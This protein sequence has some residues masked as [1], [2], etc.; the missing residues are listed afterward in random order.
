MSHQAQSQLPAARKNPGKFLRRIAALAAVKTDPDD[1]V[2]E[3]QSNV[4][5]RKSVLFTEVAQKTEYQRGTQSQLFTAATDCPVQSVDYRFKGNSSG[6]MCLRIEEDFRMEYIF[7]FGPLQIGPGHVEEIFFFLQY[8]GPGIVDVQK[9][10]QIS[11]GIG[12]TQFMHGRVGE[13]NPV[14]GCQFEHQ[15]RLK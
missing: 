10:L 15:F 3:R 13:L 12:S 4:Q 11:K 6:R 5:S 7:G 9:A 1:L 2:A 8:A 14:P